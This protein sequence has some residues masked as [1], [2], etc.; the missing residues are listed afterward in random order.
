[1]TND[2]QATERHRGR[3]VEN[4]G[5]DLRTGILDTAE[6]LFSI[7]GY[8]ATSVRKIAGQAGVNPA[9]VHYY[10]GDKRSLLLDVMQRALEPLIKAIAGLRDDP[11]TDP[12]V[13]ARLL[14]SMASERPNLP[15]L[16][17]REVLLPG[18]E[19]QQEFVQNMA[20]MIGGALPPLINRGQ[21]AGH[22]REDADPA[23][24]AMLIMALCFFPFI[25]RDL[26][27]PA[28]GIRFDAP[29]IELLTGQVTQL[30][31]QGLAT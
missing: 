11:D 7:H 26:A 31:Q 19:I 10:F 29:G 13:I 5:P 6:T 30:L 20:P 14:I 15:R 17:T 4:A 8:A 16:M 28:L 27:A 25:A 22:V 12:T 21:L 3:P 1:M 24:A 2:K 18:G 23:I 9:L